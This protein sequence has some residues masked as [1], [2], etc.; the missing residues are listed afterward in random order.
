MLSCV[1]VAG[2][3]GDLLV[4]RIFGR[5]G[6]VGVG[7]LLGLMVAGC[8]QGGAQ[9]TPTPA[10]TATLVMP[11]MT[12]NN[13]VEFIDAMVPHHQLAIDMAQLAEQYAT[14]GEV[15]G[16]ARDIIRAQQ[17]EINRFE[18]WRDQITAGTPQGPQPTPAMSH[19]A[20][21]EMPGMNV[22]LDAFV[23]SK[24]FDRSFIEA[25]LPHHETAIAMSRAALPNLKRQEVRDMAMD[26]INFQQ[27][28][29]DLMTGW[30]RNWYK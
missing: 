2:W 4:M 29:I 20:L 7:L 11:P 27:I 13:D 16:L 10:P 23:A 8:D 3:K 28:E 21:S 26:I 17:D 1:D 12:F 14:R 25:M 18:Y 6:L 19:D 24:D 30:L 15:K 5:I 22:D 9:A